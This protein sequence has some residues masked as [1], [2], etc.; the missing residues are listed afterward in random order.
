MFPLV[1]LRLTFIKRHPFKFIFNYLLL[2]TILLIIIIIFIIYYISSIFY[3]Q[4]VEMID[5]N[6]YHYYNYLNFSNFNLTQLPSY[7]N[8]YLDKY[9]CN[10]YNISI[11]SEDQEEANNF[12]TYLQQLNRKTIKNTTELLYIFDIQIF[13]NENKLIETVTNKYNS[14]QNY[15]YESLLYNEFIISKDSNNNYEYNIRLKYPTISKIGKLQTDIIIEDEESYSSLNTDDIENFYGIIMNYALYKN[16]VNINNELMFRTVF[17][18]TLGYNY[19]YIYVIPIYLVCLYGTIFLN[20][21]LK[22]I[23][24]KEQKLDI[25]LGRQGISEYQNL[26][27]WLIMFCFFNIISFI[28]SYN[29]FEID[30][31][32]KS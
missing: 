6:I 13:E 18:K 32:Y 23:D 30:I 27:S 19:I 9:H 12:K 28:S 31:L 11:V 15:G 21:V 8:T 22:M 17:T 7:Y 14:H 2:S 26:L 4:D 29:K 1:K 24:E 10:V 3:N 5:S 25:F 16:N 20:F